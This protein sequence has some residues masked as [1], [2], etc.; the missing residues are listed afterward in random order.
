MANKEVR[1]AR[2]TPHMRAPSAEEGDA[3]PCMRIALHLGDDRRFIFDDTPTAR[4]Y[5]AKSLES[6][7][8]ML[9]SEAAAAAA[10]AGAWMRDPRSSFYQRLAR[11]VRASAS[12]ERASRTEGS[13]TAAAADLAHAHRAFQLDGA[14][15][16]EQRWAAASEFAGCILAAWFRTKTLEDVLALCRELGQIDDAAGMVIDGAFID[17]LSAAQ[18]VSFDELIPMVRTLCPSGS[19]EVFTVSDDN[20]FVGEENAQQDL[21]ALR[22]KRGQGSLNTKFDYSGRGLGAASPQAGAVR[23]RSAAGAMAATTMEDEEEVPISGIEL[24][25]ELYMTMDAI[26]SDADMVG[27]V[28]LNPVLSLIWKQQGCATPYH[29]CTH[30]LPHMTLCNQV[31]GTSVFHFLPLLVGEYL[32]FLSLSEGPKALGA[33]MKRVDTLRIGS[34]AVARPGDVV[35]VRPRGAHAVFVPDFGDNSR[36][37]LAPFEISMI[38]A[39]EL[40]VVLETPGLPL[41]FVRI[42]LTV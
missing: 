21:D 24:L 1:I 14:A 9:R 39:A 5:D 32:S 13:A 25:D 23:R 29:Q 38:R 37:G 7:Q 40:Y 18:N 42:L 17:Q 20:I 11:E 12:S 41:R 3:Q 6:F 4:V 30:A 31:S 33:A 16:L 27:S 22:P 35:L 10:D 8:A 34:V 15:T 28:C 26:V 2:T 19:A 36:V